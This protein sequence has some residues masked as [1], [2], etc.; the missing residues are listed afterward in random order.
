MHFSAIPERS[1]SWEKRGNIFGLGSK[2]VVLRHRVRR[3]QGWLLTLSFHLRWSAIKFG[4]SQKRENTWG[5]CLTTYINQPTSGNDTDDV[6]FLHVEIITHTFTSYPHV[7]DPS[8]TVY[9]SLLRAHKLIMCGRPERNRLSSLAPRTC[10][11]CEAINHV[12][13]TAISHYSGL[14]GLFGQVGACGPW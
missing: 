11:P 12:V 2:I 14:L 6:L 7:F 13:L 8:G 4:Q 9:C 3:V 10:L 5:T 1:P